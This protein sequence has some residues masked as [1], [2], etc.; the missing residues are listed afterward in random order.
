MGI[1][2]TLFAGEK[3]EEHLKQEITADT[4]GVRSQRQLVGIGWIYNQYF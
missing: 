1:K 3:W 4:L 2:I